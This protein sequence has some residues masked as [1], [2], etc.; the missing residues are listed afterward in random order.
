MTVQWNRKMFRAKK[1]LTGA[2]FFRLSAD[3]IAIPPKASSINAS[4]YSQLNE[5]K[6]QAPPR[7]IKPKPIAIVLKELRSYFW[8]LAPRIAANAN[9]QMPKRAR[10][11]GGNS[12]HF[13]RFVATRSMATTRIMKKTPM[14]SIW[15]L[16][17]DISRASLRYCCSAFGAE[18]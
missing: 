13:M 10:T 6:N 14:V 16:L 11:R 8:G 9:I 5:N 17:S 7:T 2:Y 12:V 18:L 3:A 4:E 15:R 1:G